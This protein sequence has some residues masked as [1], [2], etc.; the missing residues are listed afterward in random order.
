M[1]CTNDTLCYVAHGVV[2]AT[3][4]NCLTLAMAS[5]IC[6]DNVVATCHCCMHETN[7]GWRFIEQQWSDHDRLLTQQGLQREMRFRLQYY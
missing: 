7:R 2:C 1:G 4:C 6:V 3:H 5:E